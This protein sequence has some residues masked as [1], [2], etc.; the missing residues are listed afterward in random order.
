MALKSSDSDIEESF[1][2]IEKSDNGDYT[3]RTVSVRPDRLNEGN[4][5]RVSAYSKDTPNEVKMAVFNLY[6]V[7]EDN[8]LNKHFLA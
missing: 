3:I 5:I 8:K 6:K 7:L 4:S 2:W 1:L